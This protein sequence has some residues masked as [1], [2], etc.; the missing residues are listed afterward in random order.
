MYCGH[1]SASWTIPQFAGLF[2]I[3][4]QVDP[5]LSFEEFSEVSRTTATQN[6][7]GYLVIN[8]ECLVREINTRN[9]IKSKNDDKYEKI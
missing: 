9:E 3:S 4:R 6:D 5:N 2:T 1:S 8:P 7:K